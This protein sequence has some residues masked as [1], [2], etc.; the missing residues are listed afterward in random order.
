M[1]DCPP[2]L[3]TQLRVVIVILIHLRSGWSTNWRSACTNL[4]LA[5]L[6]VALIQNFKLR[7]YHPYI[8]VRFNLMPYNHN[9]LDFFSYQLPVF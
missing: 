1:G 3:R 7:K 2:P 4:N 8:Y 5:R 9:H 6:Q